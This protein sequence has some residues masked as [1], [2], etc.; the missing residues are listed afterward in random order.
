[1]S[2]QHKQIMKS[3]FE[4]DQSFDKYLLTF[5]TGTLYL[6]ILFLKDYINKNGCLILLFLGW[7]SLVVSM[8]T[9]LGSLFYSRKSYKNLEDYLD[10]AINSELDFL[11]GKTTKECNYCDNDANFISFFEKTSIFCFISG[12][13]LIL[14]F[15]IQNIIN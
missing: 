3:R 7:F 6:S 14:I 12:V 5:S 4:L 13:V 1:M 2:D 10:V 15:F 9:A 8:F 11:E